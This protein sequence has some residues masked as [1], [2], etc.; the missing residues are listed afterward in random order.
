MCVC[1]GVCVCVVCVCVVCIYVYVWYVYICV[2]GWYVCMCV[3]LWYVYMWCVCVCVYMCMCVVFVW[4]EGTVC[5]CVCVVCVC[6]VFAYVFDM[7]AHMY[8]GQKLTST[9]FVD[10]SPLSLRQHLSLILMLISWGRL[11]SQ[12]VP[13]ICSSPLPSLVLP[14]AAAMDPQLRNIMLDF[15]T[16]VGESDLRSPCSPGRNFTDCVIH[17]PSAPKSPYLFA[18]RHHNTAQGQETHGVCRLTLC[19]GW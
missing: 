10:G 18:M 1:V 5:V 16:W 8:V 3:F 19:P 9:V 7:C 11:N 6:M 15:L 13:A 4:C 12:R 17:L 14:A 2:H